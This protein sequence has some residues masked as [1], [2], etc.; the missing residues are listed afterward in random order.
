[1]ERVVQPLDMLC[2]EK[3]PNTVADGNRLGGNEQ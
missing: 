2:R 1:M 3:E